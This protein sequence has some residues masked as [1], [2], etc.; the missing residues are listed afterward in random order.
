MHK[1]SSSIKKVSCKG[2]LIHEP[3]TG[4]G[5]QLNLISIV[6]ILQASSSLKGNKYRVFDEGRN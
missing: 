3:T 4:S 1:I 5:Y 2:L 6:N